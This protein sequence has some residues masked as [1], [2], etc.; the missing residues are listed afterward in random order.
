MLGT[1]MSHSNWL[2]ISAYSHT[3][4]YMIKT[5]LSQM[6]TMNVL[7]REKSALL[8]SWIALKTQT[9]FTRVLFIETHQLISTGQG[10]FTTNSCTCMFQNASCNC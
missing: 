10:K 3:D 8:M 1:Y 2:Y 4:V 7:L 5:H 6:P 9:S